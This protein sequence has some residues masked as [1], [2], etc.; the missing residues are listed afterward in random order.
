METVQSLD[1]WGYESSGSHYIRQGA[2][3]ERSLDLST[4]DTPDRQIGDDGWLC[5]L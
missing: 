1:H 2:H 5:W 4:R 3:S